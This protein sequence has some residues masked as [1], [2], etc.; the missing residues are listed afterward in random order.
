MKRGT[1]ELCAFNTEQSK[2]GNIQRMCVALECLQKGSAVFEGLV[3][4]IK[5]ETLPSDI[6]EEGFNI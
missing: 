6:D 2:N 1:Y 3:I 5:K 4:S